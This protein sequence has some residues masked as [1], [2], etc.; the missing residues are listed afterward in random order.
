MKQDN[1][2][3][4]TLLAIFQR[5]AAAPICDGFNFDSIDDAT[6]PGDTPLHFVASLGD[7][8][9]AKILLDAGANP[10]WPNEHPG[11]TP[12][13]NA[14]SQKHYEMVDLLLSRGASQEIKNDEGFS[15][16]D[17]AKKMNDPK[18]VAIFSS[19]PINPDKSQRPE[20]FAALRRSSSTAD[21]CGYIYKSVQDTNLI[22]DT[23]LHV[24]T[25]REEINT[26]KA[27][28]VAGA[29]PNVQGEYGYTP[30]HEAVLKNNYD[31]VRL[32]LEHGAS[33]NIRNEK[34][35]S[36]MDMAKQ[37]GDPRLIEILSD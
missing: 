31:L 3:N 25:R 26:V 8:E 30:F 10:N 29:N 21:N 12:L 7:L 11:N 33:K 14:T 19:F 2:K 5:L 23:A 6:V 20:V 34:G 37:S 17:L 35:F 13:H 28:L 9:T 15:S 32:L 24:A 22:G 1:S 16:L 18:L 27:L 36:P 4:P